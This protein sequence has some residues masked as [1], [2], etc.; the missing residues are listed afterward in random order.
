V[1]CISTDPTKTGESNT[2][3]HSLLNKRG[4][5]WQAMLVSRQTDK[6]GDCNESFS[7]LRIRWHRSLET[8]AAS[9]AHPGTVSKLSV[10]ECHNRERLQITKISLSIKNSGSRNWTAESEL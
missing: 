4:K 9:Q 10:V 1:I 5:V 6:T 8:S 2:L 3:P 7:K